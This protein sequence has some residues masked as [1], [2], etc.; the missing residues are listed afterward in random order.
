MRLT[1]LPE[2]NE[3]AFDRTAF[4]SDG[5]CEPGLLSARPPETAET[6]RLDP[7]RV[8][9]DPG[10]QPTERR[11]SWGPVGAL[12]LH[13]L[14]LL[15]LLDWPHTPPEITPP[16]IPI[17]LVIEQPPPPSQPAEP[18]P[19]A[20]PPPHRRAS[21]DMAPTAVDTPAA[22]VG[23]N[24]PLPNA[25]EPSPPSAETQTVLVAPPLPPSPPVLHIEAMAAPPPPAAEARTAA[26]ASPAP[27]PRAA[28]Y[29]ESAAVRMPKSLESVW[30]LPLPEDQPRGGRRSA[31][32]VGPPAIRDEY[33]ANALRLTLRHIGL[34]PR[35][36][37]G[38]RQGATLLTFRV[39]ED[40]TINSVRVAQSSG[41]PDIDA[42]IERMVVEVR[43]FPPLP[44]WMGPWMDFTLSLHFPHPLQQ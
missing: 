43:R 5:R 11:L 38:A 8:E 34:L 13:L 36:L 4:R 44:Q 1:D 20:N 18:K 32:L 41:Y 39:L 6:M 19:L 2:L 7:T 9:F 24:D 10:P 33:C 14:P 31:R 23:R 22:E 28:P 12:A 27:P 17:Q 35:S 3:I 26:A 30:P 29:K 15:T 25:G 40:G 16:V 37:T 42:R 21:D